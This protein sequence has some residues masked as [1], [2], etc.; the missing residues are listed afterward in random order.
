MEQRRDRR[1]GAWAL[2]LSLFVHVALVLWGVYG[3]GAPTDRF[4]PSRAIEIEIVQLEPPKAPEPAQPEK[5]QNPVHPE[6][7]KR[8]ERVQQPQ[9]KPI[10]AVVQPGPVAGEQGAP[11][12]TADATP[13]D[14]PRTVTLQPSLGV[15][16]PGL[17]TGERE[18]S[19]GHTVVNGPGEEPD[20]VAVRE[21]TEDNI[22]RRLDEDLGNG[23]AAARARN[24]LLDPYFT[25]LGSQLSDGLGKAGVQLR[26]RKA[27]EILRDDVFGTWQ[28]I[29][30]N[31]GKNGN[32]LNSDEQERRVVESGLG[33]QA[34][35]GRVNG[36]SGGDVNGQR[37][38]GKAMQQFGAMEAFVAA[39][40]RP[41]LR[42]V[43]ELRQERDGALAEAV[44][45]EKSGDAKFDEFVLHQARKVVREQGEVEDPDQQPYKE[46]WRSVWAF[47]WEPP[48]VKAKLL[49]VLRGQPAHPLLLPRP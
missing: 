33:R 32:P 34:D 43:I 23:A 2:L 10:E 9:Q 36:L 24:G 41:R 15:V 48:K 19:K 40:Q 49:R 1:R 16:L 25:K 20:A 12:K 13:Q 30:E 45:L 7:A 18:L 46:G 28:G 3:R 27:G 35:Q 38:M 39:A 22:K 14:V 21:Y 17:G 4:E 44:V 47:T 6:R 37:E 31:Y 29:A 8:V 11:A 26:E 42:T 5:A